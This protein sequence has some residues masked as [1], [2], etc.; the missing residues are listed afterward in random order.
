M[1]L[2]EFRQLTDTLDENTEIHLIDDFSSTVIPATLIRLEEL[3][4]GDPA[5]ESWPENAIVLSPEAL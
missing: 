2:R 1:T 3:E 4:D 5:K